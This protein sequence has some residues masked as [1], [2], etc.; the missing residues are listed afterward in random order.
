MDSNVAT[1]KI[2]RVNTFDEML[3]IVQTD[4]NIATGDVFFV[5]DGTN[6][7]YFNEDENGNKEYPVAYSAVITGELRGAVPTVDS[8]GKYYVRIRHKD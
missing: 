7:T 6:D 2:M 1:N 5:Q 4:P 3:G 8:Y